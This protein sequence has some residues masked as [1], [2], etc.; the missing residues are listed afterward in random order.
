M[1]SSATSGA[2][3]S[4]AQVILVPNLGIFKN[5]AITEQHR[6]QFR[7]EFFNTFNQTNFGN[8]VTNLIS[9][10]FGRISSAADPR[11]IQLALKYSF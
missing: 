11:L 4:Q 9:P 10:A 1:A 5:F 2:T 8:P 7:A 3:Y 6:L